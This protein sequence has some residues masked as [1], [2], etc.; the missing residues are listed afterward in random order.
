MHIASSRLPR[1]M[2]RAPLIFL[3]LAALSLWFLL[4]GCEGD[5]RVTTFPTPSIGPQVRF[6]RPENGRVLAINQTHTVYA[7]I[8]DSSG[9]L[10]ADFIVDGVIHHSQ[11]LTV[12]S[13]R[14]DYVTRWTPSTLGTH[15]LTI[16]GY[17]VNGVPSNQATHVVTVAN[18][19]PHITPTPT[20]WIIIVTATPAQP[21]PT[22]W[23]IIVTPQPPPTPIPTP[24]PYY[25]VVTSTP[26]TTPQPTAVPPPTQ[27]PIIIVVPPGE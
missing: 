11:Q 15:S 10:R 9:V 26:P 17:N 14:F 12:A 25:I 7:I 13:R 18:P 20:P 19:P 2:A 5:I 16:I 24:T 21:T 23:I 6:V 8:Q 22:P 1:A 4:A 27:T 3:F